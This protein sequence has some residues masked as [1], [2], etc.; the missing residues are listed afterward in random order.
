MTKVR[1]FLDSQEF[2]P[3][4]LYLFLYRN[5][6][7]EF[8][9]LNFCP[10]N[11][12]TWRTLTHFCVHV[13]PNSIFM[14][15]H[16]KM[17]KAIFIRTLGWII[18]FRV[19]SCK[20]FQLVRLV[21]WVHD[22]PISSRV[23][24]EM[25]TTIKRLTD[26]KNQRSRAFEI[27]GPKRTVNKSQKKSNFAWKSKTSADWNVRL[28]FD[29]IKAVWDFDS[30]CLTEP[31]TSFPYISSCCPASLQK[32]HANNQISPTQKENIIVSFLRENFFFYLNYRLL[33]ALSFP[34]HG[35]NGQAF[36]EKV[37]A[38]KY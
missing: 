32:N 20:S 28:F 3:W 23:R 6:N 29:L 24:I 33:V 4:S 1:I 18:N 11:W 36:K 19:D 17:W 10:V 31:S 37:F 15:L 25:T 2:D 27:L 22:H 9:G 7:F 26:K 14:R 16:Q 38:S 5:S 35:T 13:D 21:N 34:C 8:Q 30:F 12:Y